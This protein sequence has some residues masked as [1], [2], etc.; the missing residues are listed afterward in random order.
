MR[1]VAEQRDPGDVGPGVGHGQDME[2]AVDERGAV[3]QEVEDGSGPAV[4]QSQQARSHGLGVG[5][6]Q[7]RVPVQRRAEFRVHLHVAAAVALGDEASVHAVHSHG[8]VADQPGEVGVAGV[9]VVE[10]VS[11][12]VT[13][14]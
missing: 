6:V 1:G 14:V 4:E 5:Q 13:P 7:V 9:D 10:E 11:I 2:G 12:E 8:T 3:A